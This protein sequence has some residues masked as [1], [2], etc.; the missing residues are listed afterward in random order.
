MAQEIQMEAKPQSDYKTAKLI[1]GI[2][3]DLIGMASYLVPWIGEITDIIWAPIGAVVLG[4]MYRGSVG[5]IGGIIQFMEE[6]VPG[7][8]FIPTFTLVWFYEYYF[9]KKETK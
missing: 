1:I 3:L 8:D 9:S 7:I 5:K 2:F 6:A 4:L